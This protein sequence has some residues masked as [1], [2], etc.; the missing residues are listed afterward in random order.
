[1]RYLVALVLLVGLVGCQ[2]QAD[3][4]IIYQAAKDE[5][6]D[7]MQWIKDNQD[8]IY[9]Y[10]R[11]KTNKEKQAA[12]P[13]LQKMIEEDERRIEILGDLIKKNRPSGP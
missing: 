5:M 2:S 6:K 12:I 7:R 9:E 11:D 13:E 4:A 10:Q 8:T 3:K 1:M